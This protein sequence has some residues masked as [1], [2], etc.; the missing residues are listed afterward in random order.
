MTPPDALLTS[1]EALRWVLAGHE[2]HPWT[3]MLEA[4]SAR[5]LRVGVWWRENQAVAPVSV[6]VISERVV[7]VNDLTLVLTDYGDITMIISPEAP[8]TPDPLSAHRANG[9]S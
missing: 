2:G 3:R 4:Q 5:F 8:F 9:N 1:Q 7:I 6:D